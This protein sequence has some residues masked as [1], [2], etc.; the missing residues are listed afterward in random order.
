AAAVVGAVTGLN[1]LLQR[2]AGYQ[3]LALVYLMSVIIL[4]MFVARGPTLLAATLTAFLW[5]FLF[6][7]PVFTFRIE[8]TTDLMFFCTYFL[9]ALAMG[10][11]AARLR[12]QQA[13]ERR[14]EQHATAMYL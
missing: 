13:A 8:S 2:W 1:T 6:V 14:R 11:L 7:P 12:A 4:A 5:D 9:V 3:T 10:Q